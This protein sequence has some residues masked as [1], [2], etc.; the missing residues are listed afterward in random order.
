MSANASRSDFFEKK[1]STGVIFDTFFASNIYRKAFKPQ[2]YGKKHIFN[3][4]VCRRG[5][6]F[7]HA[8]KL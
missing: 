7:G 1:F 2:K 3:L 5:C 8:D 4:Y 6:L